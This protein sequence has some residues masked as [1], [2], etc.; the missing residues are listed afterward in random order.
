MTPSYYS[1]EP[2]MGRVADN[3]DQIRCGQTVRPT[4]ITM[5]F[6]NVSRCNKLFN[7]HKYQLNRELRT[8]VSD[9]SKSAS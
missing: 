4:R 8:Q 9:T 5:T 2:S 7:Y 3:G 1:D 6:D